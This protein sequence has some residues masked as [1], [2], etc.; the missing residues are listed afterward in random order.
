MGLQ[1]VLRLIHFLHADLSHTS[2][3]TGK[4]LTQVLPMHSYSTP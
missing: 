4:V 1:S 3:V 2:A